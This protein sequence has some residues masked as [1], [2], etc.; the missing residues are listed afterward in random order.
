MSRGW[1]VCRIARLHIGVQRLSIRK[2]KPRF[3][4]GEKHCDRIWVAMHDRL[5]VR[6]VMHLQNSY[7]VVLAQHGVML[8][9]DFGRVLSRKDRSETDAQQSNGNYRRQQRRS[10]SHR[11]SWELG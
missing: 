7:L 10:Q 8:G 4:T 6:P 5:L 1:S 3:R 11:F 9:I 2:S